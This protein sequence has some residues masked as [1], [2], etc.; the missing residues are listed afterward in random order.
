M[1]WHPYLEAVVWAERTGWFRD[2]WWQYDLINLRRQYDR[3]HTR[4][5]LLIAAKLCNA[6]KPRPQQ[7]R[8]LFYGAPGRANDAEQEA[9][10]IS[11]ASSSQ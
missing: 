8:G 6:D 9:Y 3:L 5:R 10:F 2:L 1:D 4:R 7:G 11:H